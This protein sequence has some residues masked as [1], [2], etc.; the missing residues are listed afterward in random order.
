MSISV[1]YAALAR[2][3][4]HNNRVH[5]LDELMRQMPLPQE[6]PQQED[7]EYEDLPFNPFADLQ[8]EM[9][10]EVR[11]SLVTCWLALPEPEDE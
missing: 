9:D 10:Q 5:D 6:Y 8:N 1:Q 11:A 7:V 2:L 3:L 4:T